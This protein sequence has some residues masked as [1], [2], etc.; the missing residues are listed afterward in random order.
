M[1]AELHR[2][3]ARAIAE[4]VRRKEI[5]AV[6]VCESA[7]AHMERVGFPNSGFTGNLR[8]RALL[9]ARAV[10]NIV[11]AGLDPGPLAG[12]PFGVSDNF[13]VSLQPTT[14][15]SVLRARGPLASHD[16]SAIKLAEAAGAILLGRQNMDEFTYGYV[17]INSTFG[18]TPNP[19]D[20]DR[21]AGGACGGSAVA[22]ARGIVPFSLASDINGSARIPSALCG[23]AGLATTFGEITTGG[24]LSLVPSMDVVSVIAGATDDLGAVLDVLRPAPSASQPAGRRGLRFGRVRGW[25]EVGLEPEMRA[26]M[27]PIWDGVCTESLALA[28]AE[29]ARAAASIIIA[30]EG[31]NL[32]RAALIDQPHAFGEHIRGRLLAGLLTTADD[33]LQAVRFQSWIRAISARL[34]GQCD[35]VVTAAAPGYAPRIDDPFINF[36]GVRTPARSHLGLYTQPIS[37]IGLPS[38]VLP[39]A[40]SGGLPLGVQLI[41][42]RG[43]EQTLLDGARYLADRGLVRLG[44]PL[45]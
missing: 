44:E 12:V 19:H 30:A 42:Q 28:H 31:A 26:A 17:T 34:F 35:I 27:E 11:D 43:G 45:G 21:V 37:L 32:H 14:A 2:Q 22:V 7:L 9:R 6:E 29:L 1:P 18:C 39:I 10:D 33:Y 36:K 8:D 4:A 13:G 16:A 38:L 40:H 23:V 25:F 24:L 41:A 15:G 20:P 5:R 3:S